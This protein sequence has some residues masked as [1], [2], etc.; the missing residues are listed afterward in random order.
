MKGE[1]DDILTEEEELEWYSALDT[2]VAVARGAR[3]PKE[4]TAPPPAEL[5]A[6]S[7]EE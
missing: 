7:P 2:P 6:Q 5:P 4:P 1:W 3:A